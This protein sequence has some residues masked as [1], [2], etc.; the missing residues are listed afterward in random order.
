MVATIV[1]LMLIILAIRLI[2]LSIA[3]ITIITN[4]KMQK[5]CTHF[6]WV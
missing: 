5:T 2:E 3:Q 6:L 1:K 4:L